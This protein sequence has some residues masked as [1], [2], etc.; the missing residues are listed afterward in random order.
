MKSIIV[1]LFLIVTLSYDSY[2]QNFSI[3]TS[4]VQPDSSAILDVSSTSKGVL[5]PRMTITQRNAI[6]N[7]ATGLI[8]WAIN[9]DEFQVY[10]GTIWKNMNG[11][12]ACSTPAPPNVNICNQV[13]MD[14]F[15]DVVNYR[16][17]DPIPKVTD[18]AT[19]ATTTSGAYCYYN[20]DS[21]NY[22]AVYGKIYNWYAVNDPRGLAPLG[23]HIPSDSEWT[24]LATCLGGTPIAGGKM[25]ETGTMH[26]ANPN[27]QA[28]NSSG[29]TGLPGGFRDYN[30]PFAD[31]T[32]AGL[33]WSSTLDLFN[34]PLYR[35]LNYAV[36]TLQ[37]AAGRKEN[38]FSVRCLKD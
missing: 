15:L 2:S 6:S 4:G 33:M 34:D 21:T 1:F 3:N 26:W 38:G 37:R 32:I 20:N 12:A 13:W 22:A 30:G 28:T 31:V 14:K 7:P 19:W 16:N 18:N 27:N 5:I 8:I 11:Y 23:W 25:K 29:F 10:N 36:G 24:V 9:C 35:W 17:G